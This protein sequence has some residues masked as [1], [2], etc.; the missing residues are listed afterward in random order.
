MMMLENSI[1][2]EIQGDGEDSNVLK[3]EEKMGLGERINCGALTTSAVQTSYH[4]AKR[5]AQKYATVIKQGGCLYDHG[6]RPTAIDM[7]GLLEIAYLVARDPDCSR[8][9]MIS[10]LDSEHANTHKRRRRT[11]DDEVV[12][13]GKISRSSYLRYERKVRAL[14]P[15]V[16]FVE[17]SSSSGGDSDDGSS[18]GRESS[19]GDG[20]GG[21]DNYYSGD[22]VMNVECVV[23][24]SDIDS[25]DS[26]GFFSADEGTP[27]PS[28][29]GDN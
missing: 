24:G 9:Q 15:H 17:C 20:D 14:V 16:S 29:S 28:P 19:D 22:D 27:P 10:L 2:G 5:T 1:I 4:I 6:G 11:P 21:R 12:V 25:D 13:L 23:G 7:C 18:G 26:A 3:G 8:S